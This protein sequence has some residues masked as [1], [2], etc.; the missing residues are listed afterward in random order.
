MTEQPWEHYLTIFGARAARV[1][2]DA[3]GRGELLYEAAHDAYQATS[4]HMTDSGW[5]EEKA[6]TVTRLFGQVVKEWLGRDG[7]DLDTLRQELKQ[8]YEQWEHPTG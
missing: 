2:A 1:P 7:Q 8:R 5:D 3:F 4:N 6:L